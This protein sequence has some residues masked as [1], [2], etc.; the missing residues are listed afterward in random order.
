MHCGNDERSCR[1][2]DTR[3]IPDTGFPSIPTYATSTFVL[4]PAALGSAV[5]YRRR[6][7]TVARWL[8]YFA[9][10]SLL[11]GLLGGILLVRTPTRMF[12]GLV[13]FLILFAPN[14]FM[15]QTSLT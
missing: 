2:R 5:A 13:P 8:R 4:L 11:G 12:D 3:D 1:R 14:L 7:R 9:P 15:A 10:V 6:I